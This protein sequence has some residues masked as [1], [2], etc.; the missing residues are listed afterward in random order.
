MAAPARHRQAGELL[1]CDAH[2]E[3]L[4]GVVFFP[5]AA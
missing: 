2:F 4:P 1:T 5:K 3:K